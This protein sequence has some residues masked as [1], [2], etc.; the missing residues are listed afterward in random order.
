VL[1]A[2]AL[3]Q[4]PPILLLDEPTT[5]LD[6]GHQQD[7]LELIDELR[8][9][10]GLAVITTMHDLTLAGRYPDT[11]MLLAG[12][13]VIITGTSD[14]VLTEE[15]LAMHYGAAVRI[16]HDDHGIVVVPYRTNREQL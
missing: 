14:E 16:I 3:A 5:A 15:H 7:A 6:I 1:I 12:G 8:R 10:R 9:S 4:E 13:K 11:L 2:R